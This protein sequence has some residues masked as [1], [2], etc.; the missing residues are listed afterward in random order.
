M[1][2][3]LSLGLIHE[4]VI[5]RGECFT[6]W[7]ILLLAWVLRSICVGTDARSFCRA[8]LRVISLCIVMVLIALLMRWMTR[9]LISGSAAS[10]RHWLLR[11]LWV[12]S[13]L[14][15]LLL[16]MLPCL[17]DQCLWRMSLLH[18][19]VFLLSLGRGILNLPLPVLNLL[20]LLQLLQVHHSLLVCILLRLTLLVHHLCGFVGTRLLLSALLLL[21][22][23]VPTGRAARKFLC[24]LG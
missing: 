15:L 13:L 20:L 4:V 10:L 16:W 6:A 2:G 14:L 17:G 3:C 23:V 7:G 1:V 22:F 19:C 9:P 24:A 5:G 18:G 12:A 11:H 8:S 21:L